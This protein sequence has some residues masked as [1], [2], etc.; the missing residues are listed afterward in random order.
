LTQPATE[1][2]TPDPDSSELTEEAADVAASI[3]GND[4][5][6]A[7]VAP[8]VPCPK[9]ADKPAK[10]PVNEPVEDQEKEPASMRGNAESD[11]DSYNSVPPSQSSP[12]PPE[13]TASAS[14]PT[15]TNPPC[16]SDS[17]SSSLHSILKKA[18][19]STLEKTDSETE[20]GIGGKAHSKNGQKARKPKTQKSVSFAQDV[21]TPT[22]GP[23]PPLRT[24]EP[25]PTSAADEGSAIAKKLV[26]WMASPQRGV[27]FTKDLQGARENIDLGLCDHDHKNKRNAAYS[28]A[29]IGKRKKVTR[30][31][32]VATGAPSRVVRT[33]GA[34]SEPVGK[35]RIAQCMVPD[36]ESGSYVD[37]QIPWRWP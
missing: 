18:S 22:P 4:P 30:N 25:R 5:A 2:F 20:A 36:Y 34:G 32:G 6:A 7:V 37:D 15:R 8:E 23:A 27:N 29:G 35:A 16:P 12:A 24:K 13:S 31:L 10:A 9:P 26:E 28:A 11:E 21:T 14:S 1:T 3:L 19:T 17:W 33:D